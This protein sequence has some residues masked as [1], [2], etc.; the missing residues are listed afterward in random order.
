MQEIPQELID[1]IIEEIH[2]SNDRHPFI[3]YRDESALL[4]ETLRACA[5]VSRAFVRPAQMRL[6]S[7]VG[8]DET[9]NTASYAQFSQ[10]LLHRPHICSYVRYLYIVYSL[11]DAEPL[12]EI[13]S[14][15]P[16]LEAIMFQLVESSWA[17]SEHPA[18]L[19]AS[20]ITALSRPT[21]RHLDMTSIN[22][23]MRLNCTRC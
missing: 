23:Q 14:S 5:L 8:F 17:W 16:N 9:E 19:K 10:L 13:L 12:S 15:L 21:L 4:L 1:A 3:L 18:R 7:A 2:L 11:D 20:F 22:L 6:F